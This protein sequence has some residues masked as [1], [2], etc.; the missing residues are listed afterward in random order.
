MQDPDAVA[1]VI[2]SSEGPSGRN[3]EYLFLLEGGLRGLFLADGGDGAGDVD[4]D[5]D[6]EGEDG[7]RT[8][9]GDGDGHVR[10]LVGRVR[11]LRRAKM[12]ARDGE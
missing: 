11:R 6:G 4:G 3:D 9:E 10:D 2:A 12:V 1:R 7:Q 5:G 8:E